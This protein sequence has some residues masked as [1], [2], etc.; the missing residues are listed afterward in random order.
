MHI[1]PMETNQIFIVCND[2]LGDMHGIHHL[3]SNFNFKN[4]IKLLSAKI[5]CKSK[6]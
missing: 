4:S 1:F 5:Q 3:K 2:F 6:I